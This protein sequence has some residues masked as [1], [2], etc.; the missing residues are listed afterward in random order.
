MIVSYFFS[1]FASEITQNLMFAKIQE[2][3]DLGVLSAIALRLD[4]WKL[5]AALVAQGDLR[6]ARLVLRY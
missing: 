3:W 6:R 4:L 2:S 5:G 1:N